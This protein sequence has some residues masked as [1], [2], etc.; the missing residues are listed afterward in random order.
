MSV[1]RRVFVQIVAALLLL[2]AGAEVYACDVSDACVSPSSTS[3]QSRQDDS[4]DQPLGDNCLCCCHHIVPVAAFRLEPTGVV[5]EPAPPGPIATT[6]A[7]C[8]PIDHPPQL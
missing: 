8:V 1:P 4:C 3:T 7:I 6:A 5:V 2:I